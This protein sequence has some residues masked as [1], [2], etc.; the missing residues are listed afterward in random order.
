M[1]APGEV[2]ASISSNARSR[3]ETGHISGDA[4]FDA[5]VG[6][7]TTGRMYVQFPGMGDRALH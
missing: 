1:R 3:R 7:P 2:A 4:S 6:R 5:R